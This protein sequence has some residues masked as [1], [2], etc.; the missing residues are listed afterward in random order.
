VVAGKFN[1]T[2]LISFSVLISLPKDISEIISNTV[3][4]RG[5]G[6][7]RSALGAGGH[8]DFSSCSMRR[9]GGHNDEIHGADC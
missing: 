1:I 7:R 4:K 8:F 5:E 2:L 3:L 6:E 9:D